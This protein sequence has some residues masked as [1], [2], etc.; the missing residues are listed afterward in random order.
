MKDVL[1]TNK[2][3]LFSLCVCVCEFEYMIVDTA[4]SCTHWRLDYTCCCLL[5]LQLRQCQCQPPLPNVFITECLPIHTD[6]ANEI[7]ADN[8]WCSQFGLLLFLNRWVVSAGWGTDHVT[9]KFKEPKVARA[10][11][12][13]SSPEGSSCVKSTLPWRSGRRNC[14]SPVGNI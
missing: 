7:W 2:C 1:L 13:L 4:Q 9:S 6:R 5:H 10:Q 11:C 14:C 3:Y 12:A 8:W